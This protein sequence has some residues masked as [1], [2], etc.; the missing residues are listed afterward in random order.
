MGSPCSFSRCI[1]FILSVFFFFFFGG[2]G[3]GAGGQELREQ[4]L[5]LDQP[6]KFLLNSKS[7]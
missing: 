4:R 1:P 6:E 7:Y 3:G 2:G 5:K